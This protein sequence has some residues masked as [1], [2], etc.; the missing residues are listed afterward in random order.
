MKKHLFVLALAVVVGAIYAGP[1]VY[2]TFTP[3]YQGIVMADAGDSD[4]Y[5]SVINKSYESDGVV[6]DPFHYEYQYEG[7]PFQYFPIEYVLGKIGSLLHLRLDVLIIAAEFFFPA[8]LVLLLYV[9]AY[10]LSNSR[11]TAFVVAAVMTVGTEL[12]HPNGI[13]NA[14]NTFVFKGN[15]DSFLLYSRPVNPQVSAL[16]F[17]AALIAI[18]NFLHNRK[19]KG[20]LVLAGVSVGA[21]AYIYPY[22]WEF[23]FVVLGLTGLYAL[24]IRDWHFVRAVLF[25]GIVCI[26]VM[27]P[28]LLANLQIFLHGGNALTQTIST[29]KIIVEKV[30][31]LPFFIYAL[32]FVWGRYGARKD[33]F[34]DWAAQFAQKYLFVFFLLITGIVVSNQQVV[35]GKL[36]EQQHFHFFTNIPAFALSMAIL[37]MEIVALM[38][39]FWRF[40]SAGMIVVVCVWFAVGVQVASYTAHAEESARYQPLAP[41]FRYL[42]AQENGAKVVLTNYYLSTRLTMYTQDF[43]YS[44]GYDSA[45]AVPQEQRVHDYFVMM[46]L[47]GVTA[48][49][50]HSYLYDHRTEVGVVIF[51]GTYWRNQCGSYGCFPDSILEELIPQYQEFVSQP[52]SK[53]I[54]THK[55]DYIL[56]DSKADPEWRFRGVIKNPPAYESGDFKLYSVI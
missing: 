32:I 41:I 44:G 12:V 46:A 45:F 23:G 34:R 42:R 17:F 21:L 54:H 14:L 28:F 15:F 4:F 47:R 5:F 36:L 50:V 18:V 1:S 35:T 8:I 43:T 2:H 25:A 51:L 31:L 13:V 26:A 24:S 48:E 6:R 16:F 39:K 3:G 33:E 7:N 38:P 10:K 11:A 40:L 53:T 27:T 56:W 19:S 37:L 52:L 22:F 30:I 29:H 20:A 49:E 9:L 55:I